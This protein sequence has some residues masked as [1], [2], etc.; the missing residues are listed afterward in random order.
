MPHGSLKL[1]AQNIEEDLATQDAQ[2][3]EASRK[4][5]EDLVD[6]VVSQIFSLTLTDDSTS[7]PSRLFTSSNEY[8]DTQ[9]AEQ[10]M[11]HP[12]STTQIFS[13]SVDAIMQGID[14]LEKPSNK[15]PPE[16]SVS[17]STNDG[18]PTHEFP[19]D[20]SKISKRSR[21]EP[22]LKRERNILTKKAHA[23][24]TQIEMHTTRLMSALNSDLPSLE[25]ISNAE[26]ELQV[27][28]STF[29]GLK[30]KTETLQKRKVTVGKSL[31]AVEARLIECRLSYPA[32]TT[33]LLYDA[34]EFVYL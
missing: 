15:F 16:S 34:G 29:S 31:S 30:R 26:K 5:N 21:S 18:N 32:A 22:E 20:V 13:D 17:S 6:D 11:P 1:H 12:S 25:A 33:P 24:L 10:L 2:A 8:R 19:V 4:Q 9:R 23:S 7:H 14:R 28:Q 27:L 3:K